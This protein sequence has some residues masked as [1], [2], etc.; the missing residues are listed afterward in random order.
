M[1]KKFNKSDP[2]E[3]VEERT[4]QTYVSYLIYNFKIKSAYIYI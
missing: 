1:K 4:E 2:D 3:L